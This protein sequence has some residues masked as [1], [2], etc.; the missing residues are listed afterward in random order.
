MHS[1]RH[2]GQQGRRQEVVGPM[3][4]DEALL[5]F[6][7]ARTMGVNRV[8]EV[9]GLGGFSAATSRLSSE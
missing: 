5:L 4:D 3:Q 2:I 6:A 1:L 9:G 7:L 8:L